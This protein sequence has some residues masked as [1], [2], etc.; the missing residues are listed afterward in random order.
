MSEQKQEVQKS[1]S[2]FLRELPGAPTPEVIE[3]WKAEFGEVFVSG[4]SEQTLFIF[5]P[6]FRKEFRDLQTKRSAPE[7]QMDNLQ[8]EEEICNICV[9]FP[10]ADAWAK[11][12]GTASSLA[13]QILAN[14]HF[15]AP[16]AASMMVQKL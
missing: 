15:F 10:R 2:D 3:K 14:S 12:A 6:L 1:L 7:S 13:E 11:L 16:G 5:R 8:Y 9:L 4:F